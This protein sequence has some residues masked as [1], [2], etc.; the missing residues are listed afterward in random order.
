MTTH[1]NKPM[2]L[3]ILNKAMNED[4]RSIVVR[5][6]LDWADR[7]SAQARRGF[8]AAL[9]KDVRLSGFT[10]SSRAL[11]SP[12][13][14]ALAAETIKA[15]HYSNELMGAILRVWDESHAELHRVALE[16]L[17]NSAEP[18]QEPVLIET[19]FPAVWSTDDM[20]TA[21]SEFLRQHASFDEDDVALM[22]C[23]LSGRAPVP[24]EVLEH[25]A[26]AATSMDRS[27]QP[28]S[29]TLQ[30]AVP[31]QLTSRSE[32]PIVSDTPTIFMDVLARLQ[33][34]SPD[35][36]EWDRM[37]LLIASIEALGQSK[38][39]EREQGRDQ[40]RQAL[41]TLHREA[42]AALDWWGYDIGAWSADSCPWNQAAELAVQIGQWQT[43][44]LQHAHLRQAPTT[45][46][47]EEQSRRK[48]VDEL[49][50]NIQ[51]CHAELDA[52]LSSG[53]PGPGGPRD[54]EKA[55]TRIPPEPAEE[56][57]PSPA[58]L[59]SG[60]ADLSVV[61]VQE[62]KQAEPVP[63]RADV[64]EAPPAG[65]ISPETSEPQVIESPYD[66]AGFEV[67]EPV[68]GPIGEPPLKALQPSVKTSAPASIQEEPASTP[69]AAPM[70][71]SDAAWH[72]LLWGMVAED[73]LAGAYWLVRSL[74]AMGRPTPIPE[75]LLAALLG[76]RWIT[77]DTAGLARDLLQIANSHVTTDH[78]PTLE[79]L[80]LA[81]ALRP[82]L[83][84]PYSGM[85]A[86]LN[87]PSCCPAL[88][89]LVEAIHLFAGFGIGL[90][91]EDVLGVA[92]E[93]QRD[94][95]IAAAAREARN[96]LDGASSRRERVSSVW[97]A[98]VGS[99]GALREFLLPVSEN[100]QE[101]VD[102]VRS[103]LRMWQDR[104]AVYKRFDEM[105][106]AASIGRPERVIGSGKQDLYREVERA[107]ELAARWCDL[108]ERARAIAARGDWF[109]EQ[110]AELREGIETDL[111]GIEAALDQ[112]IASQPVDV[113]SSGRALRIS[114]RQLRELLNLV[115]ADE[116]PPV[117]AS[118]LE[119]PIA[120]LDS[121]DAM[122]ANRLLYLPEVALNNAGAPTQEG[123]LK[124][125]SVL[126]TTR[127]EDR[128]IYS[129]AQQWLIQQDYRFF[130]RV[131]AATTDEN[132]AADLRQRYD[133]ALTAS[134]AALRASI[135][136]TG[137]LL[138]QALLD[139]VIN[140]EERANYG[141]RFASLALEEVRNF[142]A[143]LAD[144]EQVRLE[145]HQRYEQRLAYLQEQYELIADRFSASHIPAERQKEALALVASALE[146]RDV[147]VVDESLARLR[148]VLD[149]GA[150]LPDDWYA[151]AASRDY[152]EEFRSASQRIELWL[153]Q[154]RGDLR[155]LADAAQNGT[156]AAGIQFGRLG[157]PRRKEASEA[158]LSWRA[159]KQSSGKG[160]N[161]AWIATILRYLGF[162]LKTGAG[163]SVAVEPIGT[164]WLHARVQMA[165]GDLAR[166]I[167][168]FGSQA[169]GHYD[170][171]CLWERP[172]ADTIAARLR[173]L[174]LDIHTVIV[175][176]LGRITDRQ[177]RDVIRVSRDRELAIAVLDETLLV[178]LGQ[179]HDV[180][181]PAFLRCTLPFSA[182]NPYR[183]FQ[184]GDVPRE[185]FFGRED[186]ARE[187]L[188]QGGSCLVYG[189]RQLGKS[190]LL[191]HVERQ[192]HRPE[193]DQYAW[194][195]NMK[196]V[197]DPPAG[198]SFSNIWRSLREGFKAHGLLD[199]RVS[200]DRSEEIARYIRES[201]RSN[202]GRRVI[203]MLDEAD[204]FL[205][206]DAREG[207]RT[208]VALREL[209][210]GTG[211]RFKIVFAG[212][213][214]VQRF[215]GIP[216]QPLAHFG[217]P[218]C[219]GPLEAGEAQQLVRQP[220]EVLGYRFANDSAVLRILSYTNYHPGLIQYFCQE[221]LKH[222]RD[223]ASAMLPPQVVLQEDIEAVYRSS[224]VRERIRE[225]FEWTLALDM[226]YQAIAWALI[227]DQG[228][229]RDGYGRAYSPGN[230]S[231]LVREW[232]PAGFQDISTD[233][234]RGWLDELCGLGVLVRNVN[235]GQYRLRSPNM[236][237]LLGKETDIEERLLELNTKPPVVAMEAD[238]HHAP[239]DD[240]A[241]RY[242][243]LTYAQERSLSQPR[244][245]VGLIFASEALG[246]KL[247][248]AAIRRFLPADLPA[249]FGDCTHIPT[250]LAAEDLDDWLK[251]Y[252]KSHAKTERM[253]LYREV[254]CADSPAMA[255]LVDKALRFCQ[256]HQAKDRW[257][258]LLFLFDPQS[259]WQWVGL[260]EPERLGLE[261]A[262]DAAL[263]PWPWTASAVRRR[264]AQHE[265]WDNNDEG[266]KAALQAT[267]GW[268]HLLDV[269]FERCGKESDLRPSAG[270][271]AQ[272]L[273]D[274][275]SQLAS[276]FRSGLG[277]DKNKLGHRILKFV[278]EDGHG[279]LAEEDLTP[280][281]IGGAPELTEV[282][283]HQAKDF[284]LRLGLL[285]LE[286]QTLI[287]DSI[288]M[289]LMVQE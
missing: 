207:F 84:A 55:P 121:L 244:F 258:R 65:P 267:G 27:Q 284:L 170:V 215:Q 211:Q 8:C 70:D 19:E 264:L 177:K 15:S 209:M 212:L 146:R 196:L 274:P 273:V 41:I 149:T 227:E 12:K 287:A 71:E 48:A 277:V 195:E 266:T 230:I 186:M 147:R 262:A 105:N 248:P 232:W 91:Q 156:T 163:A 144:L 272:E 245:G 182:L 236:V 33:A 46:R 86:W 254:R 124:I 233:Q 108:V 189:G 4:F 113:A 220:L 278:I 96:W 251:E 180:R 204:S 179:E 72:T 49:E 103:E 75:W 100:R 107:T 112:L 138:E 62:T 183:P 216:D 270:Q 53:G 282:Q 125:A 256:R 279:Q 143:K 43:D 79:L 13:R 137:S 164:D 167:P 51:R 286:S 52:T 145:I 141:S 275:I 161:A 181:L 208:V 199:S 98:L 140:D 16:F 17:R 205:D 74:I 285:R 47:A 120:A 81:A 168:E 172:G 2:P 109:G 29:G 34:L 219:V 194:I 148:E 173:D 30:V 250:T 192:F 261:E 190:A 206:A 61:P 118:A 88:R 32:V 58:G 45:S 127:H 187:I 85:V 169:Q 153:E 202:P 115:I 160:N 73:D 269:L 150:T 142:K 90:H 263:W 174:N 235:N 191:R 132:L 255:G 93:E 9:R 31:T 92:G 203:V 59:V 268:P 289:R 222:L 214:N 130:D 110:I 237:R 151:P 198:K 241:S 26:S 97:H 217:T 42:E 38:R 135:D 87:T 122:L 280:V 213:Q 139:Q 224:Q 188:R 78:A 175:L 243:P 5:R 247:L 193:R 68:E 77:A 66:I 128:T 14:P 249:G 210:L 39:A 95:A 281:L 20:E 218:I 117:A 157:E 166:P 259:T 25:L 21:A 37:P 104:P 265:K 134:R 178:F 283:C 94:E 10:D 54:D 225:R 271:F 60:V 260:P 238:S 101:K 50:V 223:H 242:G 57:A 83:T 28:E 240:R 159:L 246:W 229:D 162:D 136:E 228:K 126:Q 221:L 24:V 7:A 64:A 288:I 119:T 76:S 6:A 35:A 63:P 102:A 80:S 3:S 226:H 40:L 129:A 165:A 231:H 82:A 114:L 252:L 1:V 158:F 131:F 200:T 197:F 201:M 234:L 67:I 22:L 56:V 11:N 185:M 257:M 69:F 111:P 99:K 116:Q 176:Y 276:D 152:L 253:I 89:D 133:E 36:Q 239:L 44:L 184:A 23:Y 106:V 155:A 18:V 154:T 123:M 171:I